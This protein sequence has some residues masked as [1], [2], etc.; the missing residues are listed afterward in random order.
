M[1]VGER[2]RDFISKSNHIQLL[3]KLYSLSR[4]LCNLRSPTCVWSATVVGPGRGGPIP[5]LHLQG[6]GS[7]LLSVKHQLGENLPRL[8]IDLECVLALVPDAVYDVIVHL[9]VRESP[10]LVNG[11]DPEITRIL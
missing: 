7:L 10:I 6:E 2:F 3:Y 8:R 4:N 11:V 9:V 5:G 1:K